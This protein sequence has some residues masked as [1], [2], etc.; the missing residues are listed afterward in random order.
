M[1]RALTVYEDTNMYGGAHCT[2]IEMAR[3]A[4]EENRDLIVHGKHYDGQ[5]YNYYK[6][7]VSG[8]R[9]TNDG[10]IIGITKDGSAWEA[11]AKLC[12]YAKTGLI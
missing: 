7:R 3:K 12:E 4:M 6:F 11:T 8:L 9:E 5:R 10:R 1:K 2:N